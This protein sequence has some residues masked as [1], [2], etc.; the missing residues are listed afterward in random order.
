VTRTI[1]IDAG[2]RIDVSDG[3]TLSK[4]INQNMDGKEMFHIYA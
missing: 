1:P 4:W 3:K 2:M